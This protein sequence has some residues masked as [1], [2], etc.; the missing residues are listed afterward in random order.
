MHRKKTRSSVSTQTKLADHM[1]FQKATQHFQT[2]K[3]TSSTKKDHLQGFYHCSLQRAD[4]SESKKKLLKRLVLSPGPG[5]I[6]CFH[7]QSSV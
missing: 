6:P 5:S 1:A 7:L 3:K 2:S 4:G